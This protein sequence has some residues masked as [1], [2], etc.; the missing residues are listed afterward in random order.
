MRNITHIYQNIIL[1]HN[2]YFFISFRYVYVA[3][4]LISSLIGAFCDSHFNMYMAIVSL[5][6]RAAILS[7]VFRK[8][9]SVSSTRLNSKFTVGEMTNFIS[10]DTDRIV[11]SCPSFHSLWSIPFQVDVFF[12][13]NRNHSQSI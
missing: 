7:T 11:N 5:K 1:Y 4:L 13:T 9:L 6:L 12:I 2:K 3:I 8:T 10:T